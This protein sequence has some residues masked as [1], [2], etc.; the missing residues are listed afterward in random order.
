MR[1]KNNKVISIL[2]ALLIVQVSFGQSAGIESDTIPE[3][4]YWN[5]G[6]TFTIQAGVWKPIGNLD[7]IFNVNPNIGG[8]AGFP[9]SQYL[10]LEIGASLNIPLNSESYTYYAK[11]DTLIANSKKELNGI[12]GVWIG[13]EK[14]IAKKLFFDKYLGVGVGMLGTGLEKPESEQSEN[15]KWYGVETINFNFG[16]SLRHII[17]RKRSVGLF[18]EYNFA[19]YNMF[20]RVDRGFGNSFLITGLLF[21]F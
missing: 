4:D 16:L 5:Y 17:F 7:K 11:S 8:R 21:R 10:R 13:H 3:Y 20:G 15:N 2:V 18:F 1:N 9:I 12:L 19:P 14:K 6:M